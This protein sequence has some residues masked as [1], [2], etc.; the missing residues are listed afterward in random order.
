MEI[1]SKISSEFLEVWEEEGEK[2]KG[3]QKKHIGT[4]SELQLSEDE[5]NQT[6]SSYLIKDG[7]AYYNHLT[8]ILALHY[9]AHLGVPL[10][11][12][13]GSSIEDEQELEYNF[14]LK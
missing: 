4:L 12:I 1:N 3:K 5:L 13:A 9:N 8:L 2:T 14:S 6:D 7:K 10:T 11:H